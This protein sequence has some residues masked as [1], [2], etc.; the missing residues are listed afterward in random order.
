MN[1]PLR[2]RQSMPPDVAALLAERD[3]Q[4]AYDERPAYQRNDYLGWIAGAKGATTRQRRMDRMLAELQAGGQY[5]GMAHPP[6]SR[7][8]H[9][10]G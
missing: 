6:S 4:E 7:T 9:S 8:A 2:L 3:L 1:R 10:P 5:M